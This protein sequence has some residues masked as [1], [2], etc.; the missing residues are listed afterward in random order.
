[1]Q[2]CMYSFNFLPFGLCDHSSKH[3]LTLKIIHAFLNKSINLMEKFDNDSILD[4]EKRLVI[5]E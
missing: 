1:M 5:N 3:S 4:L 2:I